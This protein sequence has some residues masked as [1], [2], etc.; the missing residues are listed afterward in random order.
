MEPGLR[1]GAYLEQVRRIAPPQ[2]LGRGEELA[3]LARFCLDE[4]AG[5]YSWWRAGP[6]AGKSALLS[7]FVLHAPDGVRIV[8]FFVTARLA[9]QDTREAFTEVLLAQLAAVLGQPVPAVLPE[10]TREAYLLDLQSQAAAACQEEG[11]RLVLV[12]DGLDEDRGVTTGPDA[13]SIARL[14]ESLARAGETRSAVRVAAAACAAA[15]WTTAASPVLL[16]LAP[17]AS[18]N[19][20][21]HDGNQATPPDR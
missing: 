17:S 12:V 6:W 18:A 5:P 15:H 10:A 21:P 19:P 16:L 13:H 2:L 7:A 4:G 8:S 11:R 9:A 14:T 20:A 1:P 3:E